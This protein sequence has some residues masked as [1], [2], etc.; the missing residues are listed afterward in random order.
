MEI[1]EE[2]QV[3]MWKDTKNMEESSSIVKRYGKYGRKSSWIVKRF[4]KYRRKV[5]VGWIVKWYGKYRRKVGW[6]FDKNMKKVPTVY[7]VQ[8]LWTSFKSK[9]IQTYE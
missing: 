2:R 9:L 4:G 5:H 1:M 8:Y 6:I 7:I 3:E